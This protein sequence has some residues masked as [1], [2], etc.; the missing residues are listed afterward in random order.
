MANPRRERRL[1][2]METALR[3]G[4]KFPVSAYIEAFGISPQTASDDKNEFHARM[5][6]MGIGCEM[7]HGRIWV[8]FPP[9]RIFEPIDPRVWSGDVSPGSVVQVSAPRLTNVDD[10]T[11][12]LVLRAVREK[13]PIR[14]DY[15]SVSSGAR[16]IVVSPH[17]LVTAVGRD[18]V[19]A[20]DHEK[21]AFRDFTLSRMKNV[22][23]EEK[24]SYVG[25]ADDGS[26]QS[27]VT[28]T[29]RPSA[30]L[31]EERRKAVLLG[32]GASDTGAASF[33]CRKALVNYMLQSL[34]ITPDDYVTQVEVSVSD[35]SP[36]NS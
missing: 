22:L 3:A 35:V 11:L 2:W 25:G 13:F 26:W 7:Q 12:S 6:E 8:D 31:S 20:F 17:T 14:C 34:G 16:A 30:E 33:V 18:H 27:M 5:E 10:R 29:L 15:A 36:E 28:V 32:L 4:G 24:V 21:N 9:D 23:L 19:R 1:A